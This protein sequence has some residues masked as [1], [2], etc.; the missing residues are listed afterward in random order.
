[1]KWRPLRLLV[2][3]PSKS[4][5]CWV[6]VARPRILAPSLNHSQLLPPLAPG[7][8]NPPWSPGSGKS[9]TAAGILPA[10]ITQTSC[11]CRRGSRAEKAGQVQAASFS[12][13][14]DGSAPQGARPA[15]RLRCVL[16]AEPAWGQSLRC[17]LSHERSSL[18]MWKPALRGADPRKMEAQLVAVG[19]APQ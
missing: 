6:P 16:S 10:G 14:S 12:G 8:L 7:E 18:H 13:S 4:I 11:G 1:M 17:C 9:P 5:Q 2:C 19:W 3:G 15:I